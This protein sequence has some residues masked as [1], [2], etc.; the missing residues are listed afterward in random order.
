[1]ATTPNLLPAPVVVRNLLEDLLGRDVDVDPADPV[2]AG[3]LPTTIVAMYVD[4]V[5]RLGAV[6]ALD[7]PL[8]AYCG[9]AL[10]LMPAGAAEDC[11]EDKVLSPTLAENVAELFNV[12]SSLLNRDGSVHLR[13][14]R[15]YLPD[16]SSLPND[17]RAHLLALGR[18]LDLTV[19]VARYG[20]GRLSIALAG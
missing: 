19:D 9:A 12:M 1:M 8:A 17:V 6:I 15:V 20:H 7:L 11:I 10:G 16:E 13:L 2:L 5:G 14:E 3:D 18:R 4:D